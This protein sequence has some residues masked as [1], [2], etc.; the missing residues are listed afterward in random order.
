M[1]RGAGTIMN[2]RWILTSLA[3]LVTATAV[4]FALGFWLGS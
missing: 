2:L 4:G 1:T 3:I